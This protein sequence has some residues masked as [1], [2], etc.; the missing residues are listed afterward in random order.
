MPESITAVPFVYRVTVTTL[1]QTAY[2]QQWTTA[3]ADAFVNRAVQAANGSSPRR[4]QVDPD[5]RA[6]GAITITRR[7][8]VF[9]PGT[10]HTRIEARRWRL[11]PITAPRLTARQYEDLREVRASTTPT[12]SRPDTPQRPGGRL[13]FT[14]VGRRI[15][16]RIVCGHFSSIAPAAARRLI[17]NGWLWPP[18]GRV[19]DGAPVALTMAGRIALALADH[20]TSTTSPNGYIKASDRIGRDSTGGR[21]YDGISYP[22]CSCGHFQHQ[23]CERRTSRRPRPAATRPRRS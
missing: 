3:H 14:P 16:Q 15:E 5:T 19:E 7:R 22:V 11:E 1:D 23:P 6:G 9:I 12:G 10:D 2:C 18:G 4:P 17:C 8:A 21:V 20:T 13:R